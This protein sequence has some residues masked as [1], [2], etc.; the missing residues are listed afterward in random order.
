[1]LHRKRVCVYIYKFMLKILIINLHATIFTVGSFPRLLND[2]SANFAYENRAK[3]TRDTDTTATQ[4]ID[5]IETTRAPTRGDES[6]RFGLLNE[7]SLAR[8]SIRGARRN[9]PTSN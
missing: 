6:A 9:L 5:A 2:Y 8:I 1:M 4:R 3:L 7:E